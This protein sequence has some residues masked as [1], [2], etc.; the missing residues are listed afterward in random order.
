[1]DREGEIGQRTL[2]PHLAITTPMR[3]SLLLIVGLLV[4]SGCATRSAA[5]AKDISHKRNELE[6]L[7]EEIVLAMKSLDVL[8]QELAAR[9]D[10]PTNAQSR[11]LDYFISVVRQAGEKIAAEDRRLHEQYKVSYGPY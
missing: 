6:I 8:Q 5:T 10:Y 2:S 4:T 9:G 7:R 11:D 1:M 3:L